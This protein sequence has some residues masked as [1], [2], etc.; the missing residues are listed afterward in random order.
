MNLCRIFLPLLALLFCAPSTRAVD[1]ELVGFHLGS[2]FFILTEEI[3]SDDFAA[4]RCVMVFR[5]NFGDQA[6]SRISRDSLQITVIP[7]GA[8]TGITYSGKDISGIVTERLNDSS[9]LLQISFPYNLNALGTRFSISGLFDVLMRE[10]AK[11]SRAIEIPLT[12]GATINLDGVKLLVS[13]VELPVDDTSSIAITFRHENNE[14]DP[15][16]KIQF[17]DSRMIPIE[18][19]QS[20]AVLNQI[21]E[22]TFQLRR[23]EG[24]LFGI[25]NYTGPSDVRQIAF[26]VQSNISAASTSVTDKTN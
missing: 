25:V 22:S 14:I 24:P 1:L 7:E 5:C 12:A 3:N 10:E 11:R 18:S 15:I 21:H 26:R 4:R 8:S 9:A 20:N 2:E 19:R 13:K 17:L 6:V 23:P 16:F